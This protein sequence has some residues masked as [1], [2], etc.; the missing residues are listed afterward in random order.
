M[1][2]SFKN[3]G[4]I[5]QPGRDFLSRNRS[6]VPIGIKT[7]VELDLST[8][9]FL[10]M[11]TSVRAQIADNLKNLITTNWGE[12]VALYDFGANLSELLSEFTNMEDFENEAALR[13]N[14]AIQK[15]M[16][17]I[18]PLDMQSYIDREER[19]MT[20][21]S[22]I[23]IVITYAVPMINVISDSVEVTLTVM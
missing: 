3:V 12:R 6:V 19:D 18:E 23:K 11:H 14:T 2:I 4:T 13:I 22:K 9:T 15:W 16:P 21:I 8:N 10:A 20:A 7:P 17:Y 5:K 1:A